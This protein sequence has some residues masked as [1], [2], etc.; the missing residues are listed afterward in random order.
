M[1]DYIFLLLFCGFLTHEM[2]GV[3]RTEWRLVS[4]LRKLDQGVVGDWFIFLHWP[5]L[6]TLL[7]LCFM[8]PEPLLGYGRL[9]FSAFSMVH[10]M[11][12]WVLRNH[13]ESHFQG[14]WSRTINAG[15][16]FLALSYLVL[17]LSST[18]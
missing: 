3:Q 17:W 10:P 14:A 8:A 18:T 9:G 1:A 13:R 2:D 4:G 6:T 7:W 16:G 5:I 11:L 12:H 15:T